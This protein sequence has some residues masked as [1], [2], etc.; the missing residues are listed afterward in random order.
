MR[1]AGIVQE[2]CEVSTCVLADE[3]E[4]IMSPISRVCCRIELIGRIKSLGAQV[5]NGWLVCEPCGHTERAI[6]ARPAF[7]KSMYCSLIAQPGG[8]IRTHASRA[9]LTFR[10]ACMHEGA[11]AVIDVER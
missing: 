10:S 4:T 1:L 9:N 6:L 5:V 3:Q 8:S 2:S 11:N 7:M